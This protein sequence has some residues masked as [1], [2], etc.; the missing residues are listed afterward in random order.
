MEIK[1][2]LIFLWVLFK[3]HSNGQ[4]LHRL[5]IFL[6]TRIEFIK[7]VAADAI[8]LFAHY[9]CIQKMN[10]N[11]KILKPQKPLRE[12]LKQIIK[13]KVVVQKAINEGKPHQLKD[14]F[15]FV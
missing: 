4:R 7:N 8:W 2:G 11:P 9:L 12:I 6:P 15:K 5:V 1:I 10:K 14:K 13:D 3:T